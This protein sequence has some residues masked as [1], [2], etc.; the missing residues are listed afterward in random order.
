[1]TLL[2]DQFQNGGGT[3]WPMNKEASKKL[4]H[5]EPQAKDS[6]LH[7]YQPVGLK[8]HPTIGWAQKL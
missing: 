3:W 5:S 2:F 4:V 6:L 8:T 7:I 1:M